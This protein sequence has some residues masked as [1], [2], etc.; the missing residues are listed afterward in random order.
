[1]LSLDQVF[2]DPQ[3]Q[4]QE[5]AIEVPHPGHGAVT[6]LGFPIKFAQAPCTIQRPAPELGGH[7]D[8]VLTDIGYSVEEIAALRRNST[9]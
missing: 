4:D 5:M 9:I 6:M 7:T 3:V 2:E 1:V 8:E